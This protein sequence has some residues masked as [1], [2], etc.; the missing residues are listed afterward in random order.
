MIPNKMILV[1]E[2]SLSIDFV[3][4][5]A[6]DHLLEEHPDY[7]IVQDKFMATGDISLIPESSLR[8]LTPLSRVIFI[9]FRSTLEVLGG[10]F[11]SNFRLVLDL[12]PSPQAF[13]DLL[14]ECFFL[15]LK[16]AMIT[17]IQNDEKVISY[18]FSKLIRILFMES[19]N[20]NE[21][22]NMTFLR[23]LGPRVLELFIQSDIFSHLSHSDFLE[24]QE[25][26]LQQ[27]PEDKSRLK[28]D[29]LNL[30]TNS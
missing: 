8:F 18:Q 5:Q 13:Q 14:E 23:G 29:L 21:S 12:H 7:K 11:F 2:G 30:S 20:L 10:H 17:L 3:K 24:V 4:V 22:Y 26:I 27:F 6:L 19:K 1:S 28:I 25:L 16:K 15:Y 9:Q